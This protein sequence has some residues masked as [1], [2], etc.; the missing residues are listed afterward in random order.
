MSVV[1]SSHY[2]YNLRSV[3]NNLLF[4]S[5]VKTCIGKRASSVCASNLWNNL[6]LHVKSSASLTVFKKKLKTHLFRIAF[7]V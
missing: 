3:S 6:P 4:V 5:E 2:Y 1:I 7:N